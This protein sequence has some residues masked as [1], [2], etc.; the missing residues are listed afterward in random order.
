MMQIAM[1][2]DW[3]AVEVASDT[4]VECA[5]CGQAARM[6]D[7]RASGG[8]PNPACR[9]G[10]RAHW[11]AFRCWE[12]ERDDAVAAHAGPVNPAALR[13]QW[14]R[15]HP[16]PEPPSGQHSQRIGRW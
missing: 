13:E 6:A 16:R 3:H 11:A 5:E 14:E 9:E 10:I 1:G 15:V 8:C 12:R 7:W 4:V 2:H